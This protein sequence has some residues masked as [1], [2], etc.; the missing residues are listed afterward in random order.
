MAAKSEN[1]NSKSIFRVSKQTIMLKNMGKKSIEPRLTQ[2]QICN[3]LAYPDSTIE[4]HGDDIH[5]DSPYN[6]M[7]YRKTTTNHILL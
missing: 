6:R 2:K 3:Q 1:F 5:T 4:R 7:K